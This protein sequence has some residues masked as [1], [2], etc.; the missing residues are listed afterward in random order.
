MTAN[1]WVYYD[2][3]KA[4]LLD[5]GHQLATDT[6]KVA[7]FTSSYSP[8][9][10]TDTT[11]AGLTNEV[12]NANGYTTGGVTCASTTTGNNFDIADAQWTATGGSIAGRYA[13]IYNSTTGGLIGYSL[14]DNT[15]A[16]VTATDTNTFTVA[17][18]VDGVF[19]LG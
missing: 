15:P 1:A 13:V 7:L 16:D 4:E 2:S 6:I 18:P 5:E 11:Y 19:D 12:A 17:P 8:N 9:V 3:F 14:L 10:A